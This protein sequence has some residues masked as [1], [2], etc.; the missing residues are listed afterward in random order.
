MDQ[1]IKCLKN[2]GRLDVPKKVWYPCRYGLYDCS[3]T[4]SDVVYTFNEINKDIEAGYN[5]E[6]IIAVLHFFEFVMGNMIEGD[7]LRVCRN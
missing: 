1:T 3:Y 7:V 5:D 6:E 2:G 4:F